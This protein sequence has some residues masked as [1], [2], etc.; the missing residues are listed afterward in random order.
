VTP[1]I[2]NVSG[3]LLNGGIADVGATNKQVIRPGTV[4][5]A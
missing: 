4:T 5:V 3:V 1:A 2:T